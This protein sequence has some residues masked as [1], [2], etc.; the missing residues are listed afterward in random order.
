MT[1]TKLAKHI[2]NSKDWHDERYEWH[3][4]FKIHDALMILKQYDLEDKALLE[5]VEKFIKQKGEN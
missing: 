3:D 1:D 4:L 2:F 5:Q